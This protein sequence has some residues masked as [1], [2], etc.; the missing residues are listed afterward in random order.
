MHSPLYLLIWVT[1]VC[2]LWL[3]WNLGFRSLFLDLFRERIFGLRYSLFRLG[4]DGELQFDSDIYRTLETLMCGLLRF[5]HRLTPLTYVF[6]WREQERAKREK[7]HVDISQQIALKISRLEPEVQIKVQKLLVELRR[8]ILLYMA[9][10]SLWFLLIMA[11]MMSAK[12]VGLWRPEKGKVSD[13]IAHEAYRA[14][15]KRSLTFSPA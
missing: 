12:A 7:D 13:V 2:S 11:V 1:G 8:D 3:L 9:F 15:S 5:G 10:S 14:E 6:S 4:M